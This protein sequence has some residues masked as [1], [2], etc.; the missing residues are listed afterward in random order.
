MISDTVI[1]VAKENFVLQH[2]QQCY[3]LTTLP[4]P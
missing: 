1:S 3:H 4:V 2:Q